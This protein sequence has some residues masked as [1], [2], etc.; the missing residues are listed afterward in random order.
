MVLNKNTVFNTNSNYWDSVVVDINNDAGVWMEINR[1]EYKSDPAIDN[2]RLIDQ[3]N[4]ICSSTGISAP[5]FFGFKKLPSKIN[6]NPNFIELKDWAVNTVGN[7][8]KAKGQLNDFID[9]VATRKN[10]V[11][12]CQRG[13]VALFRRQKD[14]ETVANSQDIQDFIK[15]YE[16]VI[17]IKKQTTF[18]NIYEALLCLHCVNLFLLAYSSGTQVNLFDNMN[19]FFNKY[20][21][22]SLVDNSYFDW[23][24][25]PETDKTILSI[26]N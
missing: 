9:Y 24:N 25:K 20:P 26:F 11:S 14:S 1:F 19:K 4:A 5:T 18:I 2:K 3:I 16:K 10:E 21:L 23:A 8:L 6:N 15:E 17:N 13:A 22:L 7:D 12:A